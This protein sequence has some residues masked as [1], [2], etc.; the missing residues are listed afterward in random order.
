MLVCGQINYTIRRLTA[1]QSQN[2][3][4]GPQRD[5]TAADAQALKTIF[6]GWDPQPDPIKGGLRVSSY[7][8]YN[9]LS[10]RGSHFC[11]VNQTTCILYTMVDLL[12]L[13]GQDCI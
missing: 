6:P 4:I 11:I 5:V 7:F 9:C 2:L 10:V 13:N 8:T 1:L 12:I 3:Y